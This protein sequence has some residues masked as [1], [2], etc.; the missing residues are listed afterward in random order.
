MTAFT[1]FLFPELR[2]NFITVLAGTTETLLAMSNICL[3]LTSDVWD[4]EQLD[5]QILVCLF[6][7]EKLFMSLVMNLAAL[8]Y[9]LTRGL[10]ERTTVK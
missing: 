1:V 3:F 4:N 6:I 10:A 9:V 5:G 2:E 7:V 8:R